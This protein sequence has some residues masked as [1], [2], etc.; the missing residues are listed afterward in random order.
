MRIIRITTLAL[1]IL[2]FIALTTLWLRSYHTADSLHWSD[3]HR[4]HSIASSGGRL[5]Y[6][7]AD[8]PNQRVTLP[9]RHSSTRR[10]DATP[11]WDN[12]ERFNMPQDRWLILRRVRGIYPYAP[13]HLTVSFFLPPWDVWWIPL[14][15]FV[16]I[17][18]IV[19]SVVALRWWR[20]HRRQKRGLCRECGYDLRESRDRCP[21]CGT[22]RTGA[23]RAE[24]VAVTHGGDRV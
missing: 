5:I 11:W 3:T 17:S 15:P 13:T 22:P 24:A 21:E 2:L 4:D 18:A 1:G 16:L 9:L 7:T 19:P 12:I 14:W 6:L 8:W 20:K 23:N 10:T